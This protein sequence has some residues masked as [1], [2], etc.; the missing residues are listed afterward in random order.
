MWMSVCLSCGF[1]NIR[2]AVAASG[3]DGVFIVTGETDV[4]HVSWVTEVT[5]VFC[6][7]KH[8]KRFERWIIILRL[9]HTE[10]LLFHWLT[11]FSEQGKSKSL[12]SP[13][14]SPVTRLQPV[15]ETQ[16]QLTSALS[17]FRGQTPRTSSPRMLENKRPESVDPLT[18]GLPVMDKMFLRLIHQIKQLSVWRF[19]GVCSCV[20]S[21]LE[22]WPVPVFV[23]YNL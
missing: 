18:V 10:D 1:M 11:N 20:V 9:S 7:W 13:K 4:G 2:P 3:A 19:N 14:S 16:A 6:L 17:A 12:M 5:F 15:W 22:Y 21:D 8:Q 23:H